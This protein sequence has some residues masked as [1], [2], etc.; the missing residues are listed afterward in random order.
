M[1]LFSD[2]KTILV[3]MVCNWL[4]LGQDKYPKHTSKFITKRLKDDK[5]KS[6]AVATVLDFY[7]KLL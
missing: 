6:I 2:V 1:L 4:Q 5:A 7:S 3:K